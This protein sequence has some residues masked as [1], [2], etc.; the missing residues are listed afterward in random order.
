[1]L[2]RGWAAVLLSLAAIAIAGCTATPPPPFTPTQIS[3]PIPRKAAKPHHPPGVVP[4]E[5][6][7]TLSPPGH[8]RRLHNRETDRGIRQARRRG[9]DVN[10]RSRKAVR[11][12][13]VLGGA[14]AS[15]WDDRSVSGKEM[16]LVAR[17]RT[18]CRRPLPIM[19]SAESPKSA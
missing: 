15:G 12:R 4:Q 16:L 10:L 9:I 17:E 6:P 8:R 5:S 2:G 19:L 3:R 14:D 1:M 13:P 18:A 11:G 7:A